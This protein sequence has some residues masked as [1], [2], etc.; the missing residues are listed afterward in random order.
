MRRG[1]S[2][3]RI[4]AIPSRINYC[5]GSVGETV[6]FAVGNG[7]VGAKVKASEGAGVGNPVL[8]AVVLLLDALVVVDVVMDVGAEVGSSVPSPPHP[9]MLHRTGQ[10]ILTFSFLEHWL[11]IVPALFCSR[12]LIF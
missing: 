7:K 5:W 3:L 12:S 9:P 8:I 11:A 2:K 6:G 10:A 1:E 4:C